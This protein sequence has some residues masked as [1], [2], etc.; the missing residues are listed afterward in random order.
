[1]STGVFYSAKGGQKVS[2]IHSTSQ[3]RAGEGRVR[4]PGEQIEAAVELAA[5]G[6]TQQQAGKV[7]GVHA[8]AGIG[9]SEVDVG[10]LGEPADLRQDRK[11]TRLN[12][13]DVDF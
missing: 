1:Y 13:S 11:S 12:Y 6:L 5:D 4:H 9:L 2:H 10:L 7:R 3:F 8:M